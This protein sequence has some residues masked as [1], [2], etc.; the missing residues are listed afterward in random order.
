M[1]I[2][3]DTVVKIEYT[4][5]VEDGTNPA[6]LSKIFEVEFLFGRDPVIPVLEKAIWDLEKDDEAEVTIPPEQAFG[7][8]DTSLL[9]EI[10]LSQISRPE[11]LK[12]GEI[13]QEVTDAG[14][15]IKFTVKDIKNDTVTADFNHPAAGKH[16]LLKAKIISVRAAGTVDILRSLNINRGGG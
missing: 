14:R 15:E 9:N 6:E 1:K 12:K 3:T 11:K 7:K 4:L 13:H 10:P 16:L 5:N 8:Y 2:G